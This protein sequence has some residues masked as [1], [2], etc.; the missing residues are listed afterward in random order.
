MK[1]CPQCLC[2][3]DPMGQL[4]HTTHYR[5]RGCGWTYS[6]TAPAVKRATLVMPIRPPGTA[7]MTPKALVDL[8]LEHIPPEAVAAE[9]EAVKRHDNFKAACESMLRELGAVDA[10]QWWLLRIETAAGALDLCPQDNWLAC[11]F[12]DVTRAKE[13]LGSDP[14][15]NP[16]SGKWNFHPERADAA[17]VGAIRFEILCTLPRS[18]RG[19]LHGTRQST[20]STPTGVGP[21]VRA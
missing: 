9:D 2:L 7:G 6:T 15:L 16:F 8:L 11:R 20:V 14:R 1:A 3:N 5:C 18:R 12:V 10:D 4:G 21:E 19:F 17:A 13:V